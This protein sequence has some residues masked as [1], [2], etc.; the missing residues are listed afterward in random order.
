MDTPD[1]PRDLADQ[2]P[3]T[4]DLPV[5]RYAARILIDALFDQESRLRA[6]GMDISD[7]RLLEVIELRAAV[8]TGGRTLGSLPIR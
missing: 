2:L 1:A 5:N 3:A 6:A 7:P 4:F 8:E